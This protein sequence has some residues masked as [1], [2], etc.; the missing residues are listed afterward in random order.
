MNKDYFIHPISIVYEDVMPSDNIGVKESYSRELATLA[1]IED[2]KKKALFQGRI[3]TLKSH[4]HLEE[5]QQLFIEPKR[6]KREN[7]PRIK[8]SELKPLELLDG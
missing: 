7:I 4:A 6:P 8:M 3:I 5:T 2:M 1:R